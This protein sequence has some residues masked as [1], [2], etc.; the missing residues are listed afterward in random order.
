MN[1]IIQKKLQRQENPQKNTPPKSGPKPSFYT[2][3]GQQNK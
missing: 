3:R 1:R 2:L